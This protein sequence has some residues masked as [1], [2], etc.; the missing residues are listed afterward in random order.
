LAS[1][2]STRWWARSFFP[3]V[4]G[5]AI[6]EQIDYTAKSLSRCSNRLVQPRR[7]PENAVPLSLSTPTGSP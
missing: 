1:H 4:C 6:E 2:L 3:Q 7:L 5:W